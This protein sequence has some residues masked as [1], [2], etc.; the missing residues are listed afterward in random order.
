[1]WR[2]S[3]RAEELI[4]RKDSG[5]QELTDQSR[6]PLVS[7]AR[8]QSVH[9]VMVID[10]IEAALDV[11]FDDPRIRHLLTPAVLFPLARLDG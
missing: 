1:L 9:K 6:H 7:D 10:V 3:F 5:L 4:F 2:S 11:A 8:A